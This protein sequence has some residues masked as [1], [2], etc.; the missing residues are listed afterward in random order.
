MTRR[1]P[2]AAL[3]AAL[4][5]GCYTNDEALPC[6]AWSARDASGVCRDRAFTMPGPTDALGSAAPQK[7]AATVDG[8]GRGLVGYGSIAGL[9]VLEETTPGAWS[10]HLAGAAV[11]G[12]NPSD[13][14]AGP[15][16]TAVFSWAAVNG[17]DQAVYLSE[18]DASGAWTEPASTDDAVSFP[19]TAYEPR[20]AV[21]R[22]GEWLLAWNQWRTNPHFGVATARRA[23]S[24]EPWILPADRDD[25]LS[26]EIFFSNAPVIAMNDAG[27]AIVTWYQSL[28]GPL[29]AFISERS[30]PGVPFSRVTPEDTLSPQDG[31]VDSDPVAAVKPAI[32]ADGS[33]AVAWAAEDNRGSVLVYLATRSASGVWTR[34]RD[35]DDAF[36]IPFG[37]ARG[38]QL[39]FGPAGDLFVVWYHDAGDG[40]AVYAARRRPDGVWTEPGTSP[41]RLSSAG[42]LAILPKLA[43]G[44]EGGAVVVWS[45]GAGAA[46]MRV[47]ARR[48]GAATEPWGPI[49][50]LSPDTGED[51]LSPALAVGPGDRAI[52][53]WSQ[54]PGDA[55]RL[56][57]ARCE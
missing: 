5:A 18:R 9:E 7:I 12:S 26:M 4:L 15:D 56:M 52:V 10:T 32:A 36:S 25:V 17:S 31:A 57:I 43:I 41:M 28:G 30:G 33:A 29:R 54:G 51:A 37:Y 23:S 24:E 34:P 44:P 45:E 19:T 2:L 50:V 49:E 13:L 22:S 11:G 3:A 20:L 39:A 40:N 55:A 27:Q 14:A 8:L 6:A 47:A 38:V 1:A 48:T 53:A 42:A 35:L 21:N 46:P 16:G